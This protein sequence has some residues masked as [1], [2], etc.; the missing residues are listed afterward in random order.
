MK[1]KQ[2]IVISILIGLLFAVGTTARAMDI[3]LKNQIHI[4][5]EVIR[6]HVRAN[7]DSQKDQAIKMQVKNQVVSYMQPLLKDAGSVGESREI[8]KSNLTRINEVAQQTLFSLDCEMETKTYLSYERFPV[9]QY[10]DFI[11]P[12]G[13][14]EA[15]RIDIGN[16]DG[17][18]W[19]CV[20]YPTLCFVDETHAVVPPSSKAK[21]KKKLTKAEYESL[22]PKI[23]FKVV[24]LLRT[25]YTK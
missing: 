9:K 20:M 17:K 25:V 1:T 11:F 16:A 18:N 10:G 14:Y 8:I 6:F 22:R 23:K 15:I 2:I 3:Q 13:E 7:S 21:L 19:W 4:S 24:E 12:A 5:K